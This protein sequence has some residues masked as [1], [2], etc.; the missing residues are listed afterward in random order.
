MMN[1]G[2]MA[3][4]PSLDDPGADGVGLYRTELQFLISNKSS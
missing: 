2:L 4:L 1:A 3:D